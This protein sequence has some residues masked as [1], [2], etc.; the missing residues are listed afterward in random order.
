MAKKTNTPA[1]FAYIGLIVAVVAI[2][3]TTATIKPI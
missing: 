3:A 1:R 2:V